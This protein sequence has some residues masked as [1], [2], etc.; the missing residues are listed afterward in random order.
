M[1]SA[2]LTLT[3]DQFYRLCTANRDLRLERS[4][5]GNLIIMPPTGW[6]TGS[7]NF[8]LIQRLGTWIDANGTG[9][10]FDSSTG[11]KLPNGA[12]RSP[13]VAWVKRERLEAINSNPNQFL[14]LCPDFAIELRSANDNLITLQ[15]KM[16][17]YLANGLQLGWLIN[18]QDKQV[19]VY[20]LEKAVEVLQS[21]VSLSGEGI[22]PEFI[23]SLDQ[24]L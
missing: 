17:E 14:P 24:I 19:E 22:L 3:D 21:P 13:D 15:E 6:E 23:L 20:R 2:D 8:R 11:F 18:P 1:Q 10:G 16:Q 12:I 9:V 7:R 4:A 5:E